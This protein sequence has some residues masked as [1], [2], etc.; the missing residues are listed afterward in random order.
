MSSGFRNDLRT[1]GRLL[2]MARPYWLH[3]VG[4]FVLSLLST[5]LELLSPLPLKIAVDSFVGDQPLPRW[6]AAIVPES[7][8]RPGVPL[9]V[10]VASLLLAIAC[11]SNVQALV[12][13]YLSTYTG[14]QLVLRFRRQ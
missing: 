11:I 5:P 14:T 7:A 3:I 8:T 12:A 4:M 10:A 2:G 1:C 13:S 9:L 6:F